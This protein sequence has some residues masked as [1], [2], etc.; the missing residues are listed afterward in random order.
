MSFRLVKEFDI[1]RTTGANV[2]VGLRY[3]TR[4]RRT[5]KTIPEQ[6]TSHHRSN[7]GQEKKTDQFLVLGRII[8]IQIQLAKLI[9]N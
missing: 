9:I 6:T 5:E 8:F 3:G 4:D 7:G 1:R 2:D